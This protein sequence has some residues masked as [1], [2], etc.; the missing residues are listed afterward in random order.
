MAHVRQKSAWLAFFDGARKHGLV[1][2]PQQ[3]AARACVQAYS[4]EDVMVGSWLLGLD[5][6]HVYES[7]FCCTDVASCGRAS[8]RAGM[9]LRQQ[10]GVLDA[11][12][13]EAGGDEEAWLRGG[14]RALLQM[15]ESSASGGK[16]CALYSGGCNGVCG[17]QPNTGWEPFRKCVAVV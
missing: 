17:I 1:R 3:R 10:R 12:V 9:L 2:V 13:G 16:V 5:V 8:H 6:Q 7:A 4:N 11:G 15:Q 14:G